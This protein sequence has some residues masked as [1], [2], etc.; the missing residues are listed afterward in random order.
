MTTKRNRKQLLDLARKSLERD[1]RLGALNSADTVAAVLGCRREQIS[2]L[3]QS[4]E[5]RAAQRRRAKGS[6]LQIPFESVVEY[7][8]EKMS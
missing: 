4:G 5:L 1:G 2:R 7:V 8:A 6:P 3:H